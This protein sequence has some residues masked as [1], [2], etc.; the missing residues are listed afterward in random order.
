[1]RIFSEKQYNFH[2]PLGPFHCSKF[3]KSPWSESKIMMDHFYAENGPHACKR[4]FPEN[5][6]VN[7]VVFSHVYLPAKNQ[8]KVSLHL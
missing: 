6:L 8:S 4:I 3:Q 7:L 2:V 5:I 1:M